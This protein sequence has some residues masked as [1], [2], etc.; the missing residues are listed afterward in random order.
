MSAINILNIFDDSSDEFLD[1][2]VDYVGMERIP[3][4]R[5][6]MDRTNPFTFFDDEEFRVRFRMRKDCFQ[7]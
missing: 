1:M 5:V 4:H 6:F 2:L 7:T 3:R